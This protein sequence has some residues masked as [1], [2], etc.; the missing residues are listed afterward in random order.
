[1]WWCHH[2]SQNSKANLLLVKITTSSRLCFP[3][4]QTKIAN[5]ASNSSNLSKNGMVV[6]PTSKYRNS[7]SKHQRLTPYPTST[8]NTP[9]S[10]DLTRLDQS[11]NIK[12]NLQK[13]RIHSKTKITNL[14]SSSKANNLISS[15]WRNSWIQMWK[16]RSRRASSK[17][18]RSLVTSP[19]WQKRSKCMWVICV[20]R[21]IIRSSASSTWLPSKHF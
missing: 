17:L 9:I 8:N 18:G 10:Q 7:P 15:T 12:S 5:V 20:C 4:S 14:S 1:M 2:P 6:T 21:I 16:G 13:N 19:P 11:I 3:N